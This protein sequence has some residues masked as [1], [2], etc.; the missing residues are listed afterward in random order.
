MNYKKQKGFEAMPNYKIFNDTAGPLNSLIYGQYA[1]GNMPAKTDSSGYLY[2]KP[3]G[4]NDQP[5]NLSYTAFGDLQ[6]AE[7]EPRAG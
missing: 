7:L 5:Q 3:F 1:S 2:V 4:S 6:V